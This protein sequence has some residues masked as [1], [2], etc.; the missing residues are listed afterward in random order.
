LIYVPKLALEIIQKNIL[1][2]KLYAI[3]I[4]STHSCNESILL[5]ELLF[6]EINLI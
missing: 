6:E 2:K 1:D 3:F 5:Y 4:P